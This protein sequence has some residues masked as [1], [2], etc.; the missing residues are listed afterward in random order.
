M[1]DEETKYCNVGGGGYGAEE[2]GEGQENHS[3]LAN[4]V[5]SKVVSKVM[6]GVANLRGS[7]YSYR[8]SQESA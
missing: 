3:G 6:D 8:M 7:V 5:V 2:I 4:G 1:S